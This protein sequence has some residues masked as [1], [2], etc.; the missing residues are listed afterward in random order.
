MS[1]FKSFLC[2]A[3]LLAVVAVQPV[4]A[5]STWGLVESSE[6]GVPVLMNPAIPRDGAG[7]VSAV[8]Q[9]RLGADETNDPLL[10]LP[11]DAIV[12]GQGNTYLLDSVLSTVFV[13]SPS[14]DIVRQIG[15]EG[16]GPGEFRNASQLVFMPDGSLGVLEMMP[17]QIVCLAP[18]GDPRP[19]FHPG[20][21]GH[22][23]MQHLQRVAVD[24]DQVI[25]GGIRTSVD[26]AG[27]TVNHSLVRHGADGS[28]AVVVRERKEVQA[29]GRVSIKLDS[30]R[31]RSNTGS[32]TTTAGES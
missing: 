4:S 31:A 11:K 26:S 19:G 1:S 10:G 23:G 25:L 6:N 29:G 8:Q 7:I 3:G 24:G 2:L 20:G 22:T 16:D 12:D 28:K 21:D 18:G 13:I 32:S 30:S 27:A 5:A 15:K 17:G 9:W 14:G